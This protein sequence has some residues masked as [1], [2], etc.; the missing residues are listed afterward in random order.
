MEIEQREI[1]KQTSLEM[2]TAQYR[3]Q[4][5][6]QADRVGLSD[7]ARRA[8]V[9]VGVGA[10]T[11][12]VVL[13]IPT[14]EGISHG[15]SL[16][17]ALVFAVGSLPLSG[18]WEH[19]EPH[20]AEEIVSSILKL[21]PAKFAEAFWKEFPKYGT[22]FRALLF[23]AGLIGG[24]LA[25]VERLLHRR[26]RREREIFDG[27]AKIKPS[28]EQLFV[29]GGRSSNI[30]DA[31]TIAEP[32]HIVPVFENAEG[33]KYLVSRLAGRVERGQP[34]FLSL[35]INEPAGI[36][37]RKSP[38]WKKLHIRE[39]NLIHAANGRRYL[40][41]LGCGEKAEE[42]LTDNPEFIDVTQEEVHSTA[43]KLQERLP[44]G[45]VLKDEDIV[46]IY[47]G[48]AKTPKIDDETGELTTTDRAIAEKAGIGIY[49]DTWSI[50]LKAV[51]RHLANQGAEATGIRLISS[52]TAY[53][54]LMENAAKDLNIS[55]HT[56]DNDP[57]NSTLLV[58]EQISDET[59][60]RAKR[61]QKEYPGRNI[62]ALTSNVEAYESAQKERVPGVCTALII[63]DV[64]GAIRMFLKEGKSPKE[65]QEILDKDL[66]HSKVD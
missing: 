62:L 44:K 66:L 28:G 7:R 35:D 23:E 4:I 5:E 55:C 31:L 20:A 48:S 3:S 37:Y 59:I 60:N 34:V 64:I 24:V 65:I 45:T 56:T 14:M 33:G 58:Y 6:V 32:I 29:I 54:K 51:E 52:V 30:A 19:I 15:L 27:N 22:E 1:P 38:Q 50:I 12:S 42:E 9:V 39:E 21:E 2:L 41:V 47:L 16:P 10:V 49:V 57:G 17:A 63:R 13:G 36:T 18:T 40:V 26:E 25:G 46:T 53:R 8:L 11:A 61:L 43:D